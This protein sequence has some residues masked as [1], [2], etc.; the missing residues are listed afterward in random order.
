MA[1][2]IYAQVEQEKLHTALESLA[3]AE[4]LNDAKAFSNVSVDVSAGY[5][6][7]ISRF[8]E[9]RNYLEAEKYLNEF[10]ACV[11]RIK[12]KLSEVVRLSLVSKVEGMKGLVWSS[13]GSYLL[14]V[15]KD[16]IDGPIFMEKAEQAYNNAGNLAQKIQLPHDLKDNVISMFKSQAL[17]ARG[18]KF[19]GQGRKSLEIGDTAS[20]VIYFGNA[21]QCFRDSE[22]LISVSRESGDNSTSPDTIIATVPGFTNYAEAFRLRAMADEAAYKGEYARC[23]GFLKQE[24]EMLQKTKED[25]LKS[26]NVKGDYFATWL[27][28]EILLCQQRQKLFADW[29]QKQPIKS[30][31]QATIVFVLISLFSAFFLFWLLKKLAVTLTIPMVIITMVFSLVMGG[32][33]AG[34]ANWGEGTGFFKQI[35]NIFNPK[36]KVQ[37]QTKKALSPENN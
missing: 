6:E 18:D 21:V 7:T 16:D 10:E 26:E 8:V 31:T 23:A 35:V 24:T 32:I 12:D 33:G 15:E 9:E 11:R 29:A 28:K 20:A 37:D 19:F 13:K 30:F 17:A 25:F 34:L 14:Q 2:S 5:G 36:T 4:Q 22:K 1:Q 3:K 27:E